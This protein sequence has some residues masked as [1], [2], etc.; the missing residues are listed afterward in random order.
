MMGINVRA[1]Y[2]LCSTLCKDIIKNNWGRIINMG[3]TTSYEVAPSVPLYSIS[4][5]AVLGLN[6]ILSKDF[7]KYNVRSICVYPA[8]FKSDMGRDV[9]RR[10][11]AV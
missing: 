8:A 2:V 10:G 6:M 3:S 11:K 4:K 9:V 5:H 1:L 7:S